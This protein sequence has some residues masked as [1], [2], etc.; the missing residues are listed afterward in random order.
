MDTYTNSRSAEQ[1]DSKALPIEQRS[2][3][4]AERD[5][6]QL[7]AQRFTNEQMENA[8]RLARGLRLA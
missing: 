6:Y 5:A 1:F 4:G 8:A 7:H 2:N 3:N